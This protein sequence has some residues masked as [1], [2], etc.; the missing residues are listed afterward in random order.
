MI[1]ETRVENGSFPIPKLLIDKVDISLFMEEFKGFHAQFADC[2]SREEPRE[3]F[4]QY[5]A[6]QMSQLERKS[7]EPI[8]LSVE[9]AKVRAMQYFLSDITWEEERI[10]SRY[11]GMVSEDLGDSEGVLI[12][13]EP[14]FVKKGNDSVGVAVLRECWKSRELPSGG[15]CGLCIAPRVRILG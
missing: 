11:H 9:S 3:N 6:G 14:G 2:F 10:L 4:Y 1:P 8:A 5:M 12:F 15:L 7:I 13:D